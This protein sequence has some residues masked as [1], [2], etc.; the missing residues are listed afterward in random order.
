MIVGD[1]RFQQLPCLRRVLLCASAEP[2]RFDISEHRRFGPASAGLGIR[3]NGLKS[4]VLLLGGKAVVLQRRPRNQQRH[5]GT[6]LAVPFAGRLALGRRVDDALRGLDH[7]VRIAAQ[8]R[9]IDILTQ[10]RLERRE[11]AGSACLLQ[12]FERHVARDR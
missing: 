5:G 6:E 4:L 8:Q 10:Q 2:Q 7:L 9:P 3:S 11:M 1:A 12:G